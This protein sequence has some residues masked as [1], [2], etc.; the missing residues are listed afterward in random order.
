MIEASEGG[1]CEGHVHGVVHD[2]VVIAPPVQR[3]RDGPGHGPGLASAG[4]LVYGAVLGVQG[5]GL[6]WLHWDLATRY[7]NI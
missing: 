5:G 2:H 6:Y 4:T 1:W 7:L 3:A